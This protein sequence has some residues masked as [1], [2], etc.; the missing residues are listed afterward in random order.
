M[1]IIPWN[2]SVESYEALGADVE[3]ERPS[4]CPD[5]DY[6]EL[7]FWGKRKR[8]ATDGKNSYSLFVRR[9]RCKG[10]DKTHTVLPAFLLK[11]QVYVVN[12]IVSALLLVFVEARGSRTTAE[13]IGV[14]RS[15]LRRWISRFKT[16]AASHYRRLLYL[17]HNLL[18][19]APPSPLGGYPSAALNLCAELFGTEADGL[20]TFGRRLSLATNGCLLYDQ[21]SMAP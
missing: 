11:N 14:A 21:P 13:R 7:I 6:T 18:P 15:T 17:K 1:I 3:Y 4:R 2:Q 19:L 10:C 12:L 8:F 16:S 9:V 20:K 5:C